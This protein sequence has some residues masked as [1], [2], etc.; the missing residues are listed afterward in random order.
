MKQAY[1]LSR[2]AGIGAIALLFAAGPL[3]AR[4]TQPATTHDGRSSQTTA[5]NSADIRSETSMNT[6]GA[7]EP[8]SGKL[9][10]GDQEMMQDIAHANLAEIEVG[11]M[12]LEKSQN[13]QLR[14]FAQ[15]LID[16]HTKANK[17]LETL[18]KSKG[19]S[20]P[21]ETDIQ[22][23]AIAT[24][25]QA[26]SGETFDN[27]FIQRVGVGDHQRTH[28]LLQKTQKTAKDKDLRAYAQKTMK[29]V[30]QHLAA[31]KKMEIK[32]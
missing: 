20:L 31:A 3:Q 6:S 13:E 23:K 12:A 8:R 2:F 10:E 9:T 29:V 5:A 22:H 18:A 15:R 17:E 21:N 7:S 4:P 19:A 24:A 11:K 16:D 30:A 27:Q 14:K 1:F 32:K 26:L 25:L 28:E